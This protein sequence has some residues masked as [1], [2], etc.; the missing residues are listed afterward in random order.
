MSKLRYGLQLCN[1]VRTK[2]EDTISTNMMTGTKKMLRML[3]RLT[4]R[5]TVEERRGTQ[6]FSTAALF[7]CGTRVGAAAAAFRAVLYGPGEIN[8]FNVS[9]NLIL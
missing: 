5:A 7:Y 9:L 6:G 4:R 2:A 1:Q 3:N 8:C